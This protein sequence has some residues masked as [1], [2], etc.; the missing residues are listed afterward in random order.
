MIPNS[1]KL[2]T[3]APY[4]VLLSSCVRTTITLPHTLAKKARIIK[5]LPFETTKKSE[6]MEVSLYI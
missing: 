4:I 1:N 5:S 2:Q 3:R 6:Q